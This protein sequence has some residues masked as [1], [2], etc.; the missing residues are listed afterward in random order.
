MKTNNR[1]KKN[2][3][4]EDTTILLWLLHH[5]TLLHG[6]STPELVLRP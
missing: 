3:N 2:W 6:V 5:Y 4:R 1:P